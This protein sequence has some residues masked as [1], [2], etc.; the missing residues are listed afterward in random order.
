M[1][2]R[3]TLRVHR[4][5]ALAGA[6]IL[7][8]LGAYELTD[9]ITK[10]L[11]RWWP[12]PARRTDVLIFPSQP[13]GQFRS[14]L[15]ALALCVGCVAIFALALHLAR[16]R[17]RISMILA[18]VTLVAAWLAAFL[19]AP[20]FGQAALA[21]T[22]PLAAL[23]LPATAIAPA[24]E[25]ASSPCILD[26]SALVGQTLAL[27]WG[28]WITSRGRSPATLVVGAIVAAALSGWRVFGLVRAPASRDALRRNVVE[29]LPLLVIPL[30]GILRAPSPLW[31]VVALA[32]CAGLRVVDTRAPWLVSRVPRALPALAAIW[33]LAAIY[34][35][36]HKFRELPRI[37]HAGHESGNYAWLN[38]FYHGKLFMAD[39][40]TIYGPLR[41]LVLA[42]YVALMG[43][44]AEQVRAGQ[45]LVHLGFLAVAIALGWIFGRRRLWAVGLCVFLFITT[46][47]A[48]TWLDALH[49][50]AFGWADL[51]RMMFPLFT[52][53][54]A[55]AWARRPRALVG[56]GAA[57]TLGA[58]YSQETGP[59]AIAAICIA[60]VVDS[61]LLP[62]V[63]GAQARAR[64]R[65]AASRVGA[66]LAGVV[67][68]ALIVIGIYAIFGKARMFLG[69][70]YLAVVLFA[71][72]SLGGVPF[73]VNERTFT[74]WATLMG[75][76]PHDGIILEYL[77][78]VAIYAVAGAALVTT[79]ISR[80]WSS[81]ST[82]RLALLAF[83]VATFRLAMARCDYYHLIS[84][85]APAALMLVALVAD[86]ALALPRI[87]LRGRYPRWHFAAA[88]LFVVPI[89]LGCTHLSGY[90]RAFGPRTLA[91][92]TGKEVPSTGPPFSYPDI[93]R[94][95][96]IY[97]PPETVALTH[98]IQK[99][100][101]PSDKVFIHASFADH[102][103]LYFLANRVN[104]TRCDLIAEIENLEVQE[105]VRLDLVRDPPLLDVGA[106]NGMF[107]KATVAYLHAGW[108]EV[109]RVGRIPVSVRVSPPH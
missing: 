91:L 9:P 84:A 26:V 56:W 98:V 14:Y 94:A 45:I 27:F 90:L 93:P 23:L 43:K 82:L 39:T 108:K 31:V 8:L 105:Q 53:V 15:V 109:E 12:L 62:E 86:A 88:L 38:S 81:R 11:L 102:A 49:L 7:G 6:L 73:P 61:L 70:V 87:L 106:D 72:G 19:I 68:T 71:S 79:A 101:R 5:A 29:G 64:A 34:G 97:L 37:N 100:S 10:I 20:F 96:D 83:G 4:A 48:L 44:T 95:G 76:A 25:P 74:S 35:I 41:E 80:R 69:T 60:L 21:L 42:V 54:G 51:G 28:V 24:T 22:L 17:P 107:N 85:T 36:P 32:L 99:R 30:V 75:G 77:L 3:A 40:G 89:V 78:P 47:M 46:T 67:A 16:R 52:L 58:L 55:V 33:A 103:E 18:A 1:F 50:L 2:L 65:R 57:A 92:L 59:V 66:L 13:N 104:P 63:P